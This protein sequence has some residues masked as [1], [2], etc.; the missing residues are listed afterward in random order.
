MPEAERPEEKLAEL[1]RRIADAELEIAQQAALMD[2]LGG[3]GRDTADAHARLNR[4]KSTLPGLHA[5][6]RHLLRKLQR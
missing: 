3:E 4:M 2:R 1:E 6:R 5:H